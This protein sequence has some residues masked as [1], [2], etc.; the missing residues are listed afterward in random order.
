MYD[1]NGDKRSA[2]EVFAEYKAGKIDREF[3]MEW[4]IERHSAKLI[5]DATYDKYANDATCDVY[6]ETDSVMDVDDDGGKE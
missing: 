2:A 3:L 1:L 6:G 4:L 5:D